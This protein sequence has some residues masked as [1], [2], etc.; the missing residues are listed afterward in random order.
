MAEL[1]D[2]KQ[3]IQEIQ[4]DLKRADNEQLPKS[5]PFAKAAKEWLLKKEFEVRKTTYEGYR[6]IVENI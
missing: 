5:L 6:I 4:V 3:T 1:Q 2:M